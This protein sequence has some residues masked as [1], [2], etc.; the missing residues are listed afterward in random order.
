MGEVVD[1]TRPEIEANA[2]GQFDAAEAR[3]MTGK[4]GMFY[5]TEP[6]GFLREPAEEGLRQDEDDIALAKRLKATGEDPQ[7][8][9]LVA[10]QRRFKKQRDYG[11]AG[12][13]I[14]ELGKQLRTKYSFGAVSLLAIDLHYPHRNATLKI[15][16]GHNE[17]VRRCTR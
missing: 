10:L 15:I 16:R 13:R 3:R 2:T 6:G 7:V 4:T 1:N 9:E 11:E 5:G 12:P 14:K 17:L 8:N